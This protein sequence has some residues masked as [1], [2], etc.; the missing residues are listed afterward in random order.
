[1]DKLFPLPI[2]TFLKM[3]R[4]SGGFSVR[5]V[6]NI[7]PW[8]FK[9]ILLEPLRWM[10]LARYNPKIRRHEI[11]QDPVFILGFYRSGTSY[12]HHFMTQDDRF[13]YHTNYQMIFPDMMLCCEKW[14][15]PAFDFIFKIFRVQDPVHRI[16]LSFRFPGEEDGSMTTA[17][18]RRGS[19]WGYFFPTR[20]YEYF[21]K[22]V[23]YRGIPEEEVEGW[24][25]EYLYLVKKISMSNRGKQLIL[26]SPP[27]TARMRTLLSMFPNA[28]FVLI[29]RNPYEVYASNKRF[30]EVVKSIYVVGKSR[31]VDINNLILD[32]YADTMQSFLDQKALVPEGQLIEL[33]YLEFIQNPVKRMRDVYEKLNLH[34][35]AHCAEKMQA[36]ADKQR[37]YKR[38]QHQLPADEKR[39]ATEKLKPFLEYWGYPV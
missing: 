29:H 22:Y 38:L 13:G 30:W 26:K 17:A 5:K 39:I 28:K 10:E 3:A 6:K 11:A 37:K 21:S 2:Y 33:P 4:T 9:T 35:F 34:P 18:S 23:L 1:M 20:L 19:A 32:I 25:K 8:L 36:F 16:P 15:S 31:E 12:L 24:K 14:M 27:N 7:L